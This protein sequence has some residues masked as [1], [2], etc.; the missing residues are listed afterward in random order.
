MRA[1]CASRTTRSKIVVGS[2]GLGAIERP[3]TACLTR[4][5][6]NRLLPVLFEA[7][8]LTLRGPAIHRSVHRSPLRLPRTGARSSVTVTVA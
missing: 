3:M 2:R 7:S 5:C 6:R 1:R 8:K 4:S